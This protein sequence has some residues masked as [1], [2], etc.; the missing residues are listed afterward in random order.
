MKMCPYCSVPHDKPGLFC[1]RVCVNKARGPRSAQTK[2]R[3]RTK[4]VQNPSGFAATKLGGTYIKGMQRA[5][6]VVDHCQTCGASFN[7]LKSDPKKFC[8]KPCVKRGGAREGSGRAKTGWY[9]G[10]YCGSTYELAF[11]IWHLDNEISIKRCTD[12]FPYVWEDKN[13]LYHPDF[14]VNGKIYEIKGR[15]QPV[16][17]VKVK[18]A[19]AVLV[20]K[21]QMKPYIQYVAETYKVSKDKLYTLYR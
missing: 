15:I 19:N 5:E 1:S 9:Q 21:D 18:T 17:Y 16:D 13:Y 8:S 3:I 7:T 20:D 12:K 2:E 14:V 10:I 6:R 4:A 11:L